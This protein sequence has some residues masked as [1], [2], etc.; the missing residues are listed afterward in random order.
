MCFY[1]DCVF[2]VVYGFCKVNY[3][4]RTYRVKHGGRHV[5]YCRCRACKCYFGRLFCVKRTNCTGCPTTPKNCTLS[6]GSVI[7]HGK[8]GKDDCN[9]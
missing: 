7:Q 9:W 5:D 8:I 2:I 3:R 4:G 6:N 1:F